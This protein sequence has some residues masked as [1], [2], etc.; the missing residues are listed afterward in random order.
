MNF[1]DKWQKTGGDRF[2]PNKD[3]YMEEM[4]DE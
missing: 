1:T 2:F 3:V 4:E